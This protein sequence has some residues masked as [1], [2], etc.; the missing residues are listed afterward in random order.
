MAQE[1]GLRVFR[2][3]SDDAREMAMRVSLIFAGEKLTDSLNVK[4]L[5]IPSGHSRSSTESEHNT[6]QGTRKRYLESD[7]GDLEPTQGDCQGTERVCRAV[8]DNFS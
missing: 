3:A 7:S 6:D 5:H 4:H 2:Q 8:A 1:H